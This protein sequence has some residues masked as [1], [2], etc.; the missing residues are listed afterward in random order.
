MGEVEYRTLEAGRQARRLAGGLR[1][2]CESLKKNPPLF[3]AVFLIAAV[4]I[5]FYLVW[6]AMP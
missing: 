4:A 6:L 2:T 3:V 5:T 1:Q